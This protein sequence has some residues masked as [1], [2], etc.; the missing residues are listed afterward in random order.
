MSCI[1]HK[2]FKIVC[3][4]EH[5]KLSMIVTIAIERREQQLTFGCC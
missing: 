1:L 5:V 2:L 3:Y 4:D